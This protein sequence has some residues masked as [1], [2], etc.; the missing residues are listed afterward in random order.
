MDWN[1]NYLLSQIQAEV[2]RVTELLGVLT[3]HLWGAHNIVCTSTAT[4]NVNVFSTSSSEDVNIAEQGEY[5]L[6]NAFSLQE[7]RDT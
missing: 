2:N 4:S 7:C 5:P 6:Y 3:D 1:K